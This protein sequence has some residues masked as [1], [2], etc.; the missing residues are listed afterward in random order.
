[1]SMT[2]HDRDRTDHRPYRSR[3]T[4]ARERVTRRTFLKGAGAA[5][6]AALAGPLVPKDW[7]F[8]RGDGSQTTPLQ[9][10]L[11]DCQENR[12][13]DHYYGYAPWI[14]RFGPP[15]GYSQPDG[16]GGSIEP[17]HFRRLSTPDI[18]HSWTDVHHEWQHGEMDGFYTTD[19]IW[20]MGYYTRRQLPFYYSLHD[21]FTLCGNY[22]C[23]LLGPTW[24]NRFYLA[25]GTSG[26][27]TTNGIWGYGVFDYPIILDLLEAAGVSWK[28]YNI[29]WDN[30]PRG[31]TDNVF[32]FWKRWANDPRT[33][34]RK[35]DYLRDLER[36][37]LPQVSFIV[38]SFAR[39]W[40][41]HPPADV[42]VGMGI[43]EEL[44]TAL[45]RSS[46]WDTSAY[47][48]T[49]DEHGGYFDHVPPPILDAFGAGIRVPTWVI[50]PFAKRSHIE[51]TVY[52]HVSTLKFLET[53]FGLPTLA[54]VN[55]RF[56]ESTPAGPNHEAAK[57]GVGPPA[58]PRDRLDAIGDL[59]ECF[60]F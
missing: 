58:P 22:F 9:H 49:Y 42:S 14:G 38:P 25:A 43:Q 39:G 16:N 26:G 13:F 50:S 8:A 10:V 1:M 47:I 45:R 55:H 3:S 11:I 6:A 31:N 2:G 59:T 12:S 52:D 35:N 37:R 27:I 53:V 7:A 24:P 18:G 30:V 51:G 20:A 23:S 48:L 15:P 46:A 32:V 4:Q 41:E 5:G 40:D 57:H 60:R 56:D 29:G 33:R 54:S 44:I 21:E 34:A 19:G 17:Y 28:V 36:D